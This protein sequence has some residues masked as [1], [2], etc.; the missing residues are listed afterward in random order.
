[1]PRASLLKSARYFAVGSLILLVIAV[2]AANMRLIPEG[3]LEP[4]L[5]LFVLTFFLSVAAYAAS[6]VVRARAGDRSFTF[7][8]LTDDNVPEDVTEQYARAEQ[9]V[10]AG[11]LAIWA[12]LICILVFGYIGSLV[13]RDAGGF[14]GAALGVLI[15]LAALAYLGRSWFSAAQ[16]RE[17]AWRRMGR[18][19]WEFLAYLAATLVIAILVAIDNHIIRST[20]GHAAALALFMLV[21]VRLRMIWS[22]LW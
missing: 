4:V 15:T 11:G 19:R 1:M 5:G 13:A 3:Q 14:A 12:G 18:H 22:G 20:P 10:V 21:A 8:P 16:A 2:L 9:R 17:R 7:Y 6:F